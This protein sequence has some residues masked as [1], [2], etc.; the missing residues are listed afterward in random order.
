MR[1]AVIGV[2]LG[3]SLPTTATAADWWWFGAN[4]SAP[5]RVLTY[6][7][8]DSIR[9]VDGETVEVLA[10]ALAETPSPNGEKLRSTQ[11]GIRCKTRTFATLRF[12]GLDTSKLGVAGS[13]PAGRASY[14][15]MLL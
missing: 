6:V 2:L 3:V 13:S 9:Q 15:N 8:R 10:L 7:E 14:I 12:T 1:L 4:G 5:T 11:Y